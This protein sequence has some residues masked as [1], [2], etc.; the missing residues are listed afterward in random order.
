M[1]QCRYNKI[2]KENSHLDDGYYS[3]HARVGNPPGTTLKNP[4]TAQRV[5]LLISAYGSISQGGFESAYVD[6]RDSKGRFHSKYDS[7]SHP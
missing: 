1:Q 2:D 6:G 5:V 3:V 4:Y 7:V